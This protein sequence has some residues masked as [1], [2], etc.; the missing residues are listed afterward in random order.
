[1]SNRTARSPCRP[2]YPVTQP[3]TLTPQITIAART[4]CRQCFAPGLRSLLLAFAILSEAVASHAQCVDFPPRVHAAGGYARF[5]A[6]GDL[7]NDQA[8]DIVT[9]NGSDAT[10]SVLLNDGRGGFLAPTVYTSDGLGGNPRCVKLGD[11]DGD[12]DLDIAV[13][14][15]HGFAVAVL[16]NQGAGDFAE[17]I[18]AGPIAAPVHIAVGDLDHDGD[19]DL[20]VTTSADGAV[21][22]FWNNGDATFAVPVMLDTGGTEA[23]RVE[24]GDLDNDGDLDMAV[25]N[26]GD[27]DENIAVFRNSGGGVFESPLLVDTG[28]E[29]F[30]LQLH[31]LDGD[32]DLDLAL[33]VEAWIGERVQIMLNNGD[34]AF[35]TGFT[36]GLGLGIDAA[37]LAVSDLDLDGD[38]DIVHNTCVLANDGHANFTPVTCYPVRGGSNFVM[39]G[40]VDGN[41]IPDIVAHAANIGVAVL[42]NRGDGTFAAATQ[43]SAGNGPVSVAVGDLDGDGDVDLLTANFYQDTIS[44]LQ[45]DGQG[46]FNGPYVF[47][48]GSDPTFVLVHDFE[49]D[50]DLDVVTANSASDTITVRVG[51]GN[52]SFAG[53]VNYTVGDYPTGVA[54]GDLDGDGDADLAVS[55][56]GSDNVTIRFNL[57]DGVFGSPVN[58]AA[59]DNVR[60]VALGDIDADGDRDLLAANGVSD[61][62]TVRRNNGDGTFAAPETY[63]AG[64]WPESM[65][66]GDLDQD[67]DL[68]L[69][70]VDRNG[71]TGLVLRN[72]GTGVFVPGATFPVGDHPYSMALGD[73]D[74]DG[75]LDIAAANFGHPNY[76][77]GDTA[78]L[79]NDGAGNFGSPA[80]FVSGF[81]SSGIAV[82]DLDGDGDLEIAVAVRNSDCVTLLPNGRIPHFVAQPAP[83]TVCDG[84]S[85]LLT[86]TVRS[87]ATYQ[88]RKDGVDLHDDDRISGARSS[89]LRLNPAHLDDTGAYECVATSLCRSTLS[90]PAWL[91]FYGTF[92]A[93][94][95]QPDPLTVAV[96][97]NAVFSASTSGSAPLTHAWRKDGLALANGPTGHGST[98]IGA[99]TKVL[100]IVNAQLGDAGA[101]DLVVSNFCGAL[102][103]DDAALSVVLTL[104]PGDLDGDGA[105]GQGDL[106]LLLAEYGTGAGGDLD[107]DG[108]T[109]QADLG[110]LL[111]HYG[112]PCP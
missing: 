85:A 87:E 11:L 63:P 110:I 95:D 92:P 57:G 44:Y 30:K 99:T 24:F 77:S 68:D 35:T 56:A 41:A 109:D 75:D 17:P 97:S 78:V 91:T 103:S 34:A 76:V 58:Y 7:N 53:P 105:V 32:G 94:S 27:L 38:A 101:Y 74:G 50:G 62:V 100:T 40:D 98:I 79:L 29:P 89:T 49:G 102:D 52:G 54:A 84:G 106:G 60:C 37:V 18:A 70:I 93:I 39:I 80:Y 15:F 28:N 5:M 13:T 90:S 65:A 26:R 12:D 42:K 46:A 19:L 81:E 88:W 3:L 31:D 20:A 64:D 83:V 33:T 112:E 55:N 82:G 73:I 10:V 45:N 66:L 14:S 36:Y 71:G 6:M 61:S 72:D 108:D 21:A 59:G 8:P 43:Q 111:A 16:L 69:A 1:M 67:G 2:P 47:A 25:T 51:Y 104:C 107:G 4:A 9:A 22:L 96:G 48:T 86:A 23:G